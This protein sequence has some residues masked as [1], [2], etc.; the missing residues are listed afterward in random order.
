[1]FIGDVLLP[2]AFIGAS[3]ATKSWHLYI[4]QG[5]FV[6]IGV[7]LIYVPSTPVISQWFQKRRSLA[8]GICAAGSGVGGIVMCFAN[9][10]MVESLGLEWALR[11]TAVITFVVNLAAT[12]LMR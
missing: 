6:G 1:M 8:N 11:I 5:A 12:L 4:S 9:E 3:F 10:A 2:A 7:G